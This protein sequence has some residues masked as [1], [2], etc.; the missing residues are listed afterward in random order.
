MSENVALMQLFVSLVPC[1][2][3]L[4]TLLP[5]GIDSL[6]RYPVSDADILWS[7]LCLKLNSAEF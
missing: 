3:L 2:N 5:E 4:W 6:F 1:K 7:L